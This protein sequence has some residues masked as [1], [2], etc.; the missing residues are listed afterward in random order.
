MQRRFDDG[1]NGSLSRHFPF[2]VPPGPPRQSA[3]RNAAEYYLLLELLGQGKY[4][5][6]L[7]KRPHENLRRSY[8]HVLHVAEPDKQ[9]FFD[10]RRAATFVAGEAEKVKSEPT[11]LVDLWDTRRLDVSTKYQELENQFGE[12]LRPQV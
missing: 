1:G 2:P 4:E 9:A 5:E 12:R 11:K 10:Y 3:T 6:D 8:L 7:F